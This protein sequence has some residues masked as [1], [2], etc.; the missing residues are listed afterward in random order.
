MKLLLVVSF[1]VVVLATPPLTKQDKFTEFKLAHNKQ[2]ASP[3][4]EVYRR[5]VFF[6]NLNKINEH[7]KRFD[8]GL[9][10]YKLGLNK[11]ADMTNEEFKQMRGRKVRPIIGDEDGIPTTEYVP[12]ENASIPDSFDWRPQGAV[13][14]IKDQG[15]CGGCW[16]FSVTGSL[17][18]QYFLKNGELKSF[19]EQNLIDCSHEDPN[20]GCDGGDMVPSFKYIMDNGIE[21]EE[22]Y[23]FE[24]ADGECR[25]DASKVA[26]QVTEIFQI[27]S[28]SID[29]LK[30]AIVN[31]GPISVA[32]DASSWDF[33]L[34]ES[35]IYT[36][37]DCLT[38]PAQLDHAVVGI[39]YGA[40]ENG[41]NYWLI[42]NQWGTEWGED[43]YIRVAMDSNDCGITSDSSFG[44][45]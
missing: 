5:T 18:G 39:G 22:D 16:A 13:T 34:Y 6:T 37:D 19:S 14:P 1:A 42:K 9:V 8:Q 24:A 32:I 3:K 35:G 44:T 43:G 45:I 17:E 11:F 25:F 4:E 30:A 38:D 26:T 29:D 15:Q 28:R 23:P 7:N 31:V 41:V 21:T 10:S 2:Y 20:S 12:P 33:Q 27:K 40:D 36:E